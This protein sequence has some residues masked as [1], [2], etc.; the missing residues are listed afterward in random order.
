M[1]TEQMIPA[2]RVRFSS[3]GSASCSG[4]R[5]EALGQ[6][7]GKR[8]FPEELP[9][10]LSPEGPPGFREQG[11]EEHSRLRTWASDRVSCVEW[12]WC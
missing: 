3:W 8:R 6:P 12:R 1:L 2:S 11:T 10:L 7:A 4:V 9:S 5:G